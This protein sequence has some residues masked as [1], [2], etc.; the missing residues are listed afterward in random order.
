MIDRDPITSAIASLDT[1]PLE[2]RFAARVAARARLEL[3]ARARP[4]ARGS[5]FFLGM[6]ARLVPALLTLAALAQTAATGRTAAKIYARVE[7]A[8]S[9]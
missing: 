6:G 1:P 9:P 3:R 5:S 8:P 7:A 4:P 2:P